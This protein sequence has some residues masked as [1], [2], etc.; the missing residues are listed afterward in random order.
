MFYFLAWG[1]VSFSWASSHF[2][3]GLTWSK[4]KQSHCAN[5]TVLSKQQ[6]H[7]MLSYLH[8]T[9][10]LRGAFVWLSMV[11][12]RFNNEINTHART[13]LK[14]PV[15][16]NRQP[17]SKPSSSKNIFDILTTRMKGF[18][19]QTYSILQ[20]LWQQCF[21]VCHFFMLMLPF[22]IYCSRNGVLPLSCRVNT[23]VQHPRSRG[24]RSFLV[25]QEWLLQI[26]VLVSWHSLVSALGTREHSE[27]ASQAGMMV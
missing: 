1:L 26:L 3:R 16:Q 8:K 18:L 9:R 13:G 7:F 15:N 17:H 10:G 22:F 2:C 6:L 11:Q 12:W 14:R 5:R 19:R 4:M 24:Q 21:G 27:P 23:S 20:V 25:L